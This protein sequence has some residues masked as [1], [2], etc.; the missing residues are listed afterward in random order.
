MCAKGDM[1]Q[2]APEQA[3]CCRFV[4]DERPLC[5]WD[6]NIRQLNDEFLDRFDPGFFEYVAAAHAQ[7]LDGDDQQH[8]AVAL[9]TSC[10]HAMETMFAMIAAVLQAPDCVVGWLHRY[11]NEELKSVVA[12]IH[13]HKEVLAKVRLKEVSWQGVANAV[14]SR[15][16]LTD[17][18]KE[19]RIKQEF[20]QFWSRLADDF[21]DDQS[22]SEY[23]GFKH[24]LR[25]GA[26]GFQL[27]VGIEDIPGQ[28][29]PP[30]KMALIGGSQFGSTYYVPTPFNGVPALNIHMV[31]HSRN[32]TPENFGYRLRLISISLQNLVSFVRVVLG[33]D[34][35]K[36]KFVWP[37]DFDVFAACWQERTNVMCSSFN[38]DI[39]AENITALTKEEIIQV[40]QPKRER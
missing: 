16:S 31:Q 27:A 7:A 38:L 26:G 25:L 5:V 30:E 18:A 10:A 12:K 33:A 11:R 20:G 36:Q 34:P 2:S 4:I 37:E 39:A 23:N 17:K 29:C 15:I 19:Q 14:F 13:C 21:L 28:P 1:S 3:Q 8:A 35:T 6:W 24:G 32:W 40:Y 22:S 9:R